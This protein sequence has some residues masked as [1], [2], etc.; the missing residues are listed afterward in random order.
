MNIASWIKNGR[1]RPL[2]KHLLFHVLL[3]CNPMDY[4][5]QGFPW[6]FP[7]KNTGVGCH[8]LLHEIFLVQGS[9][10]H[11]LYLLHWQE[12]SLPLSHLGS[13]V[14]TYTFSL[15]KVSN[16][17]FKTQG[18]LPREFRPH[19]KLCTRNHYFKISSSFYMSLEN[20]QSKFLFT[21]HLDHWGFPCSSFGKESASS[22]G[23]LGLIPRSGT[24]PRDG[25]GN[26]LQ[27]SCLE[28]P[29]TEEPGRLQSMGLQRV[30]HD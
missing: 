3:F 20:Q 10:L 19:Q 7:G 9:R 30:G 8:F 1:K 12:D 18:K 6:D 24:S 4:I 22:A 27:Y 23:D 5:L 29:W 14:Q 26:P 11:L 28:N 15:F 16:G 21:Y 17:D 2:I 25:I 13:Q